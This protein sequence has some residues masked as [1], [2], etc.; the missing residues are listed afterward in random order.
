MTAHDH[1]IEHFDTIV[2]G[3]GQTGLTVG[4]ELAR[5]GIGFVILDAAERVGDAWR[6]RWDSLMLFTPARYSGLPGM[7]FPAEPETYVSKDEV[8]E[9]LERY[10]EA[11]DLPVRS[12]TRVTRLGHD[13][14]SYVVEANGAS[15]RADNVVVAMA[16]YQVPHVPDFA[17]DLDPDIIQMHSSQYK[18]PS[19]LADGPVL[20]VGMGNSGADIGLELA[21]DRTTYIAGEPAAVIPFRIE[22]WFGRTIGVRLVRFGAVKVLNTSTPIGRRARERMLEH[23]TAAPLVR[24]KP[25]DLIDAG[26][27][28]V[29]RV[30]GVRDGLP[31]IADGTVLDV[32]N[33]VWCTGFRPGFDWIELPV[34]DGE[35]RPNHDRGIVNT[36]PG[37]YFCGLFFLHALWSETLSG[38]PIDAKHVV[39]HLASRSRS[40]IPV[41]GP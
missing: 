27:H 24:V 34:F 8:A 1:D 19:Q 41:G 4:Y 31:L 35:G 18:R 21:R 6:K 7:P 36:H 17:P 28:R 3:G 10:A 32:A 11:G 26:A 9:Y 30:S 16:N 40:T 5:R 20:V 2:I 37:L 39:E 14:H 12:G 29:A 22:P 38:M 13:G 33:V 25:R 15:L 23:H